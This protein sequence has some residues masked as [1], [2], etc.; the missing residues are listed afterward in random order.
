M[1]SPGFKFNISF[2]LPGRRHITRALI[3]GILK[4]LFTIN[5]SDTL[6][7]ESIPLKDNVLSER[8]LLVWNNVKCLNSNV[9]MIADGVNAGEMERSQHYSLRWNNHQSHLLSAFDSLL[10][11][12]FD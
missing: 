11:V 9:W 3:A 4:F 6:K 8:I 1:N 2:F 12:I 10:Q 7:L 5:T